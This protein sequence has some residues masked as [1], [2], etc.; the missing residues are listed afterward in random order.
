[1]QQ[2]DRRIQNVVQSVIHACFRNK[3]NAQPQE[4]EKELEFEAYNILKKSKFLKH[5]ISNRN[6]SISNRA[7]SLLRSHLLTK[8]TD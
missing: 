8:K 4:E 1:M 6:Q 7:K 2:R 5:R 3:S